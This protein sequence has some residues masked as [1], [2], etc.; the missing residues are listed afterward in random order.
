MNAVGVIAVLAIGMMI[1]LGCCNFTLAQD[2]QQQPTDQ[3]QPTDQQT[4]A[5]KDKFLKFQ[6]DMYKTLQKYGVNSGQMMFNKDLSE[7]D[8][9]NLNSDMWDLMQNNGMNP[10]MMMKKMMMCPMM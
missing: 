1:T 7:Q 4:S 2:Q 3:K 6:D 9:V 5:Y 10:A 8:W